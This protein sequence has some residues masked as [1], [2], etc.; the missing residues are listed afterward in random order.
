M[1]DTRSWIIFP[2][3]VSYWGSMDGINYQHLGDLK[4]NIAADNYEVLIKEFE[5]PVSQA[6]KYIKVLAKNYGA[7]PAWHLGYGE[8]G[9]AILFIDEISV[10]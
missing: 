3:Q 2:T 6:L 7:L 4:N 5:L 8:G 10:R 9:D 1:Q